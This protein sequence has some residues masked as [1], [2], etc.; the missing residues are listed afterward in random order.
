MNFTVRDMVI[1]IVEVLASIGG[2]AT[3]IQLI[4]RGI[5]YF[6]FGKTRIGNDNS[7]RIERIERRINSS[8]GTEKD[9]LEKQKARLIKDDLVVF[10]RESYYEDANKQSSDNKPCFGYLFYFI[11][12]LLLGFWIGCIFYVCLTVNDPYKRLWNILKALV[13]ALFIGVIIC[14][15]SSYLYPLVFWYRGFCQDIQKPYY[16]RQHYYSEILDEDSFGK[17]LK[18]NKIRDKQRMRSKIFFFVLGVLSMGV[19]M[20]AVILQ[21]LSIKCIPIWSILV[22]VV[23]III[24]GLIVVCYKAPKIADFPKIKTVESENKNR[25]WDEDKEKEE[26]FYKLVEYIAQSRDSVLYIGSED[27]DNSVPSHYIDLVSTSY[28]YK[29]IGKYES[30][31]KDV[32]GTII[33]DSTILSLPDHNRVLGTMSSLL[34]SDGELFVKIEKVK[35]KGAKEKLETDKETIEM[36]GKVAYFSTELEQYQMF[37]FRKKKKN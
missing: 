10:A 26:Y 3:L 23:L 19:L 17:S 9:V 31:E 28:T 27:V 11:S 35:G 30:L 21:K 15:S 12:G 5:D 33:I 2:F 34:K 29:S 25:E 37:G 13:I 20:T 14:L 16:Y 4:R 7:E 24:I 32:Y 18:L 36:I 22:F 6:V 8:K 1:S